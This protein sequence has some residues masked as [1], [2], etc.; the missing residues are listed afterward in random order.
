MQIEYWW[1]QHD[2]NQ[3][4]CLKQYTALGNVLHYWVAPSISP[5]PAWHLSQNH[6]EDSF[7]SK[8]PPK[9]LKCVTKV[10]IL[11][12]SPTQNEFTWPEFDVGASELSLGTLLN[13][14]A[15]FVL[16]RTSPGGFP[17]SQRTHLVATAWSRTARWT[18]RTHPL[19]GDMARVRFRPP[20]SYHNSFKSYFDALRRFPVSNIRV[21]GYPRAIFTL[22]I[23]GISSF[24]WLKMRTNSAIS[25]SCIASEFSDEAG[26]YELQI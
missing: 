8:T 14:S 20:Q 11:G 6:T 19:H 7:I 23:H 2:A 17:T 22:Q 12:M 10:Q 9:M 1:V 18:T 26:L 3:V 5:S 24:N 13:G 25:F 16:V 4:L 21:A 15:A